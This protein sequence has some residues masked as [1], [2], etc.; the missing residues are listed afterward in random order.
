MPNP[1][2]IW[3]A[4]RLNDELSRNAGISVG[5]TPSGDVIPFERQIGLGSEVAALVPRTCGSPEQPQSMVIGAVPSHLRSLAP[6]VALCTLNPEPWCVV[7]IRP[8]ARE[9]IGLF[10]NG[11]A[12][13]QA[14]LARKPIRIEDPADSVSN[15]VWSR[16][17]PSLPELCP[18][19]PD[20]KRS[21]LKSAI[22]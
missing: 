18:A 1:E 2:P 20:A 15:E 10:K 19:A 4:E 14:W 13:L 17:E 16:C 6:F 5:F 9:T 7:V 22:E 11:S 12:P 3:S 21:W 8:G